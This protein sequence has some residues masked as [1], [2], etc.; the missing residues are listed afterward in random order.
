MVK[1]HEEDLIKDHEDKLND[2][3]KNQEVLL[4]ALGEKVRKNGDRDNR[5]KELGDRTE[6][7]DK[8]LLEHIQ[9]IKLTCNTLSNTKADKNELPSQ[10]LI[11]FNT[12]ILTL[13]ILAILFE[14]IK[15]APVLNAL[16]L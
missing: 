5:I 16:G 14:N 7:E 4:Y 11:Y 3:S 1:L 2:L 8:S 10:F 6:E 15:D 13:F 12:I 9:D